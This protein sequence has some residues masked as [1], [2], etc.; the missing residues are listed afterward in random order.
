MMEIRRAK[1]NESQAIRKFEAKAWKEK[2][3]TSKYDM[4]NSVRFSYVFVAADKKR[5]IG[6]I[7][8]TRTRDDDINVD[9]WIVDKKYQGKG[10]GTKLYKRLLKEVGNK[11]ILAFTQLSNKVS[12]KAH[13]KL[14]FNIAKKV[15]DAYNLGQP[16]L[17]LI[18]EKK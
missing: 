6:L 5:I 3:L 14:G 18:R 2:N 8:A 4:A 13:K 9:E 17:L 11:R 12:Q 16:R 15:E 10:I 7:C 1:V